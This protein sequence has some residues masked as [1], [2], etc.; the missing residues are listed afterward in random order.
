MKITSF[1]FVIALLTCRL[2][3]AP[4]TG[5]ASFYGWETKGPRTA[6]GAL[7]DPRKLTAATPYMPFGTRLKVTNLANRR[8]VIVVCNDR[9][10]A[11]RL[12]RQGRIIDLSWG[13]FERLADPRLGLIKVKIE[14]V[15]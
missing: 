4:T 15:R 10:P 13:A 11:K 3:G 6:S 7:W 2:I 14:V 12:V 1:I 5:V 9:G 8:S